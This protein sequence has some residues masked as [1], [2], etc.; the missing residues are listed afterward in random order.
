MLANLLVGRTLA[1]IV[2]SV[3]LG[4]GAAVMAGSAL[5]SSS[6]PDDTTAVVQGQDNLQDPAELLNYGQ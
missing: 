4:G 5:V 1:G 2:A 3:L 6:A